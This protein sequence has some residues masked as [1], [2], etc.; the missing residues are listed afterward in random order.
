[1][2][3]FKLITFLL[4]MSLLYAAVRGYILQK[5][6]FKTNTYTVVTNEH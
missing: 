4:F 6:L 1:M 3:I 2:Q 5:T